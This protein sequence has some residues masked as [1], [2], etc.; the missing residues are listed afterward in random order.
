MKIRFDEAFWKEQAI[1]GMR[2]IVSPFGPVSKIHC[3]MRGKET[4]SRCWAAVHE[5]HCIYFCLQGEGQI[6]I[7]A[8]PYL[9]KANEAIGVLP[10]HPHRR[11]KGDSQVQYLLLRFAPGEPDLFLPLFNGTIQLKKQL[12]PLIPDIVDVYEKITWPDDIVAGNELGLRIGLLLNK[13]MTCVKRDLTAT[14][15][16]NPRLPGIM[17]T[18]LA[19][20][21]IGLSLKEIAFKLNITSGHL[22]DLVHDSMGYSPRHIQQMVRHRTAVE[23]LLHTTLSISQVA[24]RSGFRSVY[25][26]SRFFTRVAGMSPTA[27]RRKYGKTREE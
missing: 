18:L 23:C 17:H 8:V 26:F 2:D 12:S 14:F 6:E 27:F 10:H 1:E 24:E 9:I 19:P 25:A 4:P 3:W 15:P 22:T 7:D 13:L 11:L 20:E 5:F 16:A 21:N